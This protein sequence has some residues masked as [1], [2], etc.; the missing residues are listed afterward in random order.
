[1]TAHDKLLETYRASLDRL[2]KRIE[3]LE[4]SGRWS[5][6]ERRMVKEI[7]R[8]VAELD[9]TA[10]RQME[11]IVIRSWEI[12]AD[13]TRRALEVTAPLGGGLNTTAMQMIAENAADALVDANHRFGRRWEDNLRRIGLEMA[14]EKLSTAQTIRQAKAR[15]TETLRDEGYTAFTDRNGRAVRLD[16]YAAMVA[17]TT[18]REATN[19]ATAQTCSDYNCDLVKVVTRLTS[20]H[21]CAAVRERV[22]SISGQDARF[23]PLNTV[24]GYK[25]GFKTIH[26]N[27]T[28][29]LVPIVWDKQSPDEQ[30]RYLR[31]AGKP[32]DIDP[33]SA[34]EVARY[35]AAQRTNRDRSRD[36]RQYEAYKAVLGDDA[37]KTFSGFRASKRS[38]SEHWRRIQLDY[39]RRNRLAKNPSL[40]LPGAENAYAENTK[41]ER[42]LFDPASER[43]YS[44]GVAFSSHL[45]YTKDNWDEMRREIISKA[46]RYPAKYAGDTERGPKYEQAMVLYGPKRNPMDVMVPWEIGADGP[47]MI[48]A[49]PNRGRET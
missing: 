11:Q 47:R 40:T 42:Y 27:C 20:C 46:G 5:G 35:N 16:A 19:A 13:N 37:P 4:A 10:A 49:Q 39:R 45:G 28:C 21:V 25:E 43:G 7:T 12:A 23:P 8:A 1:M 24:H 30:A 48:T 2:I 22:F 34:A 15:L 41:F 26:P 14:A 3:R 38:G 31:D 33:R 29:V 6:V 17:R 36:R 32:M 9:K 18:S 44:K